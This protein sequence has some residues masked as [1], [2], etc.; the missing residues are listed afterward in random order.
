ML[1]I[2]DENGSLEFSEEV[3]ATIAGLAAAGCPGVV[4]MSTRRLKDELTE[5]LG[6]ES[7]SKGVTIDSRGNGG[8]NI[9]LNIVVAFGVNISAL[10]RDIRERVRSDIKEMTGLP[11][12]RVIVNV[13][14]VRMVG[15]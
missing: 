1:K 8:M 7:L 13:R 6:I 5:L 10:A 2:E 12:D 14:G 4:G 3:V 11:V 9:E 15:I